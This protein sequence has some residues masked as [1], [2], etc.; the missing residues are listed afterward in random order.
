M[1]SSASAESARRGSGTA[2]TAE[3]GAE[4]GM[5]MMLPERDK[6]IIDIVNE[7]SL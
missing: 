1:G 5:R 7:I 2:G 3:S 6:H 4:G